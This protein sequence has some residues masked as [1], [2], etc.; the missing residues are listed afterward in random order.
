M[1]SHARGKRFTQSTCLGILLA[2]LS[3]SGQA[4]GMRAERYAWKNVQ[5][6]GGGFVTGIVAHPSE[7][8]LLYIRTDVGGCYRWDAAGERW[9]PLLDWLPHSMQNLYGGESI[10]IDPSNPRNVYFAGGMFDWWRGGPWDVLKSTNQGKTWER[11][12]PTGPR[13]L[14]EREIGREMDAR[15]TCANRPSQAET[16][17]GFSRSDF[18]SCTIARSLREARPFLL[19]HLGSWTAIP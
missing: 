12:N 13:R 19:I 8:N 18:G 2:V 9:I 14:G 5:W 4:D 11:T 10:A 1:T 6:G 17:S 15:S 3:Y 16:D 7:P